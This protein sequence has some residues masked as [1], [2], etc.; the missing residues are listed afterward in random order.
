[1][2]NTP[3]DPMRFTRSSLLTLHPDGHW[4]TRERPSSCP[5]GTHRSA[6]Y[7]GLQHTFWVARHTSEPKRC[8]FGGY[9]DHSVPIE[10]QYDALRNIAHRLNRDGVHPVGGTWHVVAAFDRKDSRRWLFE[11]TDRA[12]WLAIASDTQFPEHEGSQ[13]AGG[14]TLTMPAVF[15]D[16]ADKYWTQVYWKLQRSYGDIAMTPLSHLSVHGG[17]VVKTFLVTYTT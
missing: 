5:V 11:G 3:E 14:T 16:V 10:M 1:M 7:A 12:Q 9:D 4:E 13:F 6:R 8:F 15:A 17:S 2:L